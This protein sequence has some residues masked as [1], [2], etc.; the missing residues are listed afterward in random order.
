VLLTVDA[1]FESLYAEA[2]R[3]SAHFGHREH[4]QVTWL[5]VRAAGA[6]R[7]VTIISEGIKRTAR[8]AGRPQKFHA[9]VSRA[10]VA[11][12]AHQ[13][14]AHPGDDFDEF[15]QRS[16]DLLDKRLLTRFY[17]SR[18]LAGPAA[19][20]GWVEPDKAPFPWVAGDSRSAT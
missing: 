1:V 12:V 18:T 14:A 9:T 8:Y 19:R 6:D 2:M 11:L 3:N 10:W 4:V 13:L 16:P 20:I 17:H 5:A 7:A 15:I